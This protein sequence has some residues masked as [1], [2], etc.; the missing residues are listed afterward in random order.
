MKIVHVSEEDKQDTHICDTCEKSFSR[1]AN[2]ARHKRTFHNKTNVNF[3][4]AN[5]YKGINE[6]PCDICDKIF[7]RKDNLNRH[8]QTAHEG[9]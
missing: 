5:S 1:S 6:F 2:L 3:D 7:N 9:N 8:K 4:F